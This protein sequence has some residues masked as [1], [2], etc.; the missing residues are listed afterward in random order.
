MYL[1]GVG[2]ALVLNQGDLGG[3]VVGK[4]VHH[5]HASVGIPL[6]EGVIGRGSELR[7][8]VRKRDKM[9]LLRNP[10]NLSVKRGLDRNE[11]VRIVFHNGLTRSLHE[12]AILGVSL[13]RINAIL[14]LQTLITADSRRQHKVLDRE[15]ARKTNCLFVDVGVNGHIDS[16]HINR[17]NLA[18]WGIPDHEHSAV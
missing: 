11:I 5:H 4:I 17:A 9:R 12:K 18:I 8:A 14:R 2:C 13:V 3:L 15:N 6:H 10:S 16:P 7:Y 1:E